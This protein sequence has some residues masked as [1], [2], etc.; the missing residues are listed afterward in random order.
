MRTLGYEGSV[1]CEAQADFFAKSLSLSRLSSPCF[2]K[3]FMCSPFASSYDHGIVLEL[4]SFFSFEEPYQKSE[5]KMRYDKDAIYWMGYF[6]RYLVYT[7]EVSSRQ[8]YHAIP[9]SILYSFYKPYHSFDNEKAAVQIL[10]L[11]P[12]FPANQLQ[13]LRKYFASE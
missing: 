7:R 3:A 5:A 9:A 8:V 4:S 12:L 11:Y 10:S 13:V 2:I 1:E 6:Y